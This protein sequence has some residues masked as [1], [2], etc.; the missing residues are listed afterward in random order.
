ALVVDDL[1]SI[2]WGARVSAGAAVRV[3]G[4]HRGDCLIR[5][6]ST[7]SRPPL[8]A[9]RL[10][11]TAYRSPLTAYRSPLSANRMPRLTLAES[12]LLCA[13]RAG[14]RR[15]LG[16]GCSRWSR[17]VGHDARATVAEHQAF[18]ASDVAHDHRPQPDVAGGAQFAFELGDRTE[19]IAFGRA[20]VHRQRLAT[21]RGA[22]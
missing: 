8:T 22:L 9:H 12:R 21:Q 17:C 6:P 11:L 2:A 19:R 15:A 7:A 5:R 4:Q 20:V 16:R 1:H 13:A 3:C 10:P 14:V 18:A